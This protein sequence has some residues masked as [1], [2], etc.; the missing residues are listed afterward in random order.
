MLLKVIYFFKGNGYSHPCSPLLTIATLGW[1]FDHHTPKDYSH[2][3]LD[4]CWIFIENQHKTQT[5]F[6]ILLIRRDV[7]VERETLNEVASAGV[8]TSSGLPVVSASAGLLPAPFFGQ[9]VNFSVPITSANHCRCCS[10]LQ[11]TMFSGD[12]PSRMSDMNA[13][14]R[15]L[16][17]FI[18]GQPTVLWQVFPHMLR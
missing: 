13:H 9:T 8:M 16:R 11:Y 15:G 18:S 5:L 10:S 14:T 2:P 7:P 12:L 6:K 17:F 1:L 4:F 3:L